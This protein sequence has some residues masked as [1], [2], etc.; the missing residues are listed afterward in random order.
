[1]F[2]F[3]ILYKFTMLDGT[4]NSC[5]YYGKAWTPWG[6]CTKAIKDIRKK[7]YRFSDDRFKGEIKI[8]WGWV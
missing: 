2:K 7:L 6:L 4:I 3:T 1:M 8:K 5:V